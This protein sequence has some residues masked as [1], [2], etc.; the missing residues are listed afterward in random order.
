MI[1]DADRFT[2]DLVAGLERVLH[3]K[4]KL[5]TSR[6]AGKCEGQSFQR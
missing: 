4:V 1:Q 3:G 2:M 5:S 6:I